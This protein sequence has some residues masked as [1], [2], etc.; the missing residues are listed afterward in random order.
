MPLKKLTNKDLEEINGASASASVSEEDFKD[1]TKPKIKKKRGRKK[2]ENYVDP[3]IFSDQIVQFYEDEI[4]SE[5]LG[6]AISDI[7]TRLGFAPN[8]INYTYKEEM[9]GDAT[10]KMFKALWNKKFTPER[11]N[12]FSYYTK[13]AFNAF[14]NRIKKEKRSREAILG[15]Q[16]EVYET[17]IHSGNMPDDQLDDCDTEAT[18]DN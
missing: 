10:E 4:L 2:K 6:K 18:Y 12:A 17:L 14:C 9:I 7:A 16:S 13:I 8:F 3:K 15:Y 1:F 11:G 5:E